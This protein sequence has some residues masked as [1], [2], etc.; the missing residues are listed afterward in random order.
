MDSC[1][2]EELVTERILH[3]TFCTCIG[4]CMGACFPDITIPIKYQ[5]IR[6]GLDLVRTIVPIYSKIA[7]R[8]TYNKDLV[9]INN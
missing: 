2:Q 3:N 9:Y 8:S 5:N 6:Q 7:G 1:S 4:A